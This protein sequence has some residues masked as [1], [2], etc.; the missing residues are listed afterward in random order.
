[1]LG[2]VKHKER[3][4]SAIVSVGGVSRGAVFNIL[5]LL[6][7][8]AFNRR[9]IWN[10]M[11]NPELLDDDLASGFDCYHLI[12]RV[13][14]LETVEVWVSKGDFLVRRIRVRGIHVPGNNPMPERA[15]DLINRM[16]LSESE[17][18][19]LLPG[20]HET[21]DIYEYKRI[22][23]NEPMSEGIFD[24]DPEVEIFWP[25]EHR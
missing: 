2:R 11:E 10:E 21:E 15:V 1:L 12:G 5:Y 6:I 24:F 4:L 8:E 23:V 17:I 20:P 19:K 3:L 14:K 7:P 22:L 13:A 25:D 18:R 9:R 16:G